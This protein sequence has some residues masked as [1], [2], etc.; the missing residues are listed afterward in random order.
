MKKRRAKHRRMNPN[1]VLVIR[2]VLTGVMIFSFLGLLISSIWYGTRL[3]TFTIATI[4]ISGGE[5][6]SHD[7]IRIR[8]W[9]EL[10]GTYLKIVPRIFSLTFPKQ[11]ILENLSEVER[12]KD[13][14]ISRASATSISVTFDEYAPEAL[15]CEGKE[16]T[17]CVFIDDEGYAFSRAPQ[18]TG[19]SLMRYSLIGV[20][21]EVGKQLV[22]LEN[23]ETLTKLISLLAD[24]GWYINR[25]DIDAADDVY[26]QV[27]GGGEL[28]VTLTQTP[29]ETVNNLLAVLR[30]EEFTNIAPGNFKYIDL[31]F[32][33]KVFVNEV[34]V[35]EEE[36]VSEETLVESSADAEPVENE[37]ER[38]DLESVA[39]VEEE[40]ASTATT[41]DSEE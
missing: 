15:W 3:N 1:T 41:T 9:T 5:T 34:L 26:L 30:A 16:M 8:T 38:A 21:P 19:G 29:I 28:K 25:A 24:S 4:D 22:T 10:Q 36:P 2:Q 39:A 23:Y 35:V 20:S 6:I 40:V 11:D 18:L 12:I 14:E 32:G 37:D 33:N 27:I 31:R 7:E 17:N 13:I